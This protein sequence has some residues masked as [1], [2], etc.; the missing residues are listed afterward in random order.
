MKE[1][2]TEFREH[3]LPW[4]TAGIAVWF[5]FYQNQEMADAHNEE[6]VGIRQ[7]IAA[8][9]FTLNTQGYRVTPS[10]GTQR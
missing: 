6:L 2:W 3:Y 4:V 8:I 9:S 7:E 10:Q 5:M 1:A